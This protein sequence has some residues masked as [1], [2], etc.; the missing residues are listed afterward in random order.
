MIDDVA[1]GSAAAD[2]GLDWDQEVTQVLQPIWQPNKYLLY[3]PIFAA[4]GGLILVQR[5]RLGREP[6][7]AAA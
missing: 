4:L 2:A 3:V 7:P 5:S 6:A 1:Y